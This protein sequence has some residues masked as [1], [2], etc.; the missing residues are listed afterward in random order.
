MKKLLAII[1]ELIPI[2]S[3][4]AFRIYC[5]SKWWE[6]NIYDGFNIFVLLGFVAFLGFVF[7][8]I[9]EKL[10]SEDSAVRFF[11]TLDKIVSAYIIFSF[12]ISMVTSSF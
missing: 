5:K 7:A 1:V 12:A 8:Y 6:Y 9:G 2:V 4:L 3:I 11:G 10:D